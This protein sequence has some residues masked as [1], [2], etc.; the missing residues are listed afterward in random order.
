MT[1]LKMVALVF[2]AVLVAAV[3]AYAQLYQTQ[4]S[5]TTASVPFPFVVTDVNM[6]NVTLPAGDYSLRSLNPNLLELKGDDVSVTIRTTE[7]FPSSEVADSKLVFMKSGDQYLLHQI[8]TADQKHVH[9]LV[10]GGNVPE[11]Y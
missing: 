7:Q 5:Y 11:V 10:H 9:D 6:V 8:W 1:R 3:P 2:L 4:M